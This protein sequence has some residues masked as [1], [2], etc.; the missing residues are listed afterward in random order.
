MIFCDHRRLCLFGRDSYP[1]ATISDV[2]GMV[3]Q[4]NLVSQFVV[5]ATSQLHRTFYQQGAFRESL[6]VGWL[7][8]IVEPDYVKVLEANEGESSYWDSIDMTSH[9]GNVHWPA[10][11]V[12]CV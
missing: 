5:V 9:F 7:N 1:H 2:Q 10:V 6:V 8:S 4:P 3:P 11:H 12:G